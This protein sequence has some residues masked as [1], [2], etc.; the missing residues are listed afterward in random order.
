M[1]HYVSRQ[2][3]LRA[4][5]KGITVANFISYCRVST[6]KQGRSGLGLAAQQAA[7]ARHL[8]ADDKLIREFVEVESGKR[9]DRPQLQ[10]AL[11]ECRRTGARLVIAKLDRLSRSVAFIA[12]LLEAGVEFTAC[13]M[14]HAS[15][16]VL[17]VMAAVAEHEREAIS[18]RTKA[19]LAAARAKGTKLGGHRERGHK[20]TATEA[21]RGAA[22]ST[23]TR[24]RKAAQRR[25]KVVPLVEELRAAGVTSLSGIARGLNELGATTPRGGKWQAAQVGR[26]LA[27]G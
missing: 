9:A 23:T 6:D 1:I 7:V 8:G 2:R 13:D 14:P 27:A 12:Q 17:H 16:F 10:A 24:Q 25:A 18:T 15:K 26:L 22:A 20:L 19:A 4:G 5:V 11:A 3:T 21:L